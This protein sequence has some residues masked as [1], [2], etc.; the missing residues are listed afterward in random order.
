[1]AELDP[2]NFGSVVSIGTRG[3]KVEFGNS[4]DEECE[5]AATSAGISATNFVVGQKWR[6]SEEHTSELQSHRST[7]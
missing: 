6:R 7:G 4:T 1:V 2:G 5:A 3:L